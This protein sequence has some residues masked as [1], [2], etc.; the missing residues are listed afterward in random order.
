M[1]AAE[2]YWRRLLVIYCLVMLSAATK[3][4]Y[5]IPEE[6]DA[7]YKVGNVIKDADFASKY[8]DQGGVPS[9]LRFVSD[10]TS[11]FMLGVSRFLG[12]MKNWDLKCEETKAGEKI[13]KVKTDEWF[14]GLKMWRR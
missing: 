10:K 13:T 12:R 11:F 14:D 5:T 4:T 1:T 3:L 2:E 8:E 7:G 9:I 6:K